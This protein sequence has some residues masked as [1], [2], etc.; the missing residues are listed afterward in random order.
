LRGRDGS[1]RRGAGCISAQGRE[2][3]AVSRPLPWTDIVAA[4]GEE[5]FAEIRASVESTKAD[6][7]DRDAFLLN[8]SAAAMLRELMPE[9]APAEMISAYGAL[10]HMIYLGWANGW[11]VVTVSGDQ[12]RA[13]TASTLPLSHSPMLPL[14]A[15]IQLPER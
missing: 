11:P 15:Y 6:P 1:V 7:L 2:G 9:E 5:H 4:I 3:Y 10:L 8:G 14:V 13:Q 12:V